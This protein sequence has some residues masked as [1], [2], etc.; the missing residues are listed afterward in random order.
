MYIYILLL[1]CDIFIFFVIY[2]WE[3]IHDHIPSVLQGESRNM[4]FY[5]R[6]YINQ[7]RSVLTFCLV[8]IFDAN[9]DYEAHTITY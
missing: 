8:L 9:H 7:H 4:D 1:N 5:H 3:S 2:K 6:S